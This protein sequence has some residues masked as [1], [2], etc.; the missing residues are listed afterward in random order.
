MPGV[1]ECQH[2]ACSEL[3]SRRPLHH[4]GREGHLYAWDERD[5]QLATTPGLCGSIRSRSSVSCRVSVPPAM[6]RPCQLTP[7]QIG[8]RFRPYDQVTDVNTA[9]ADDVTPDAEG[10]VVLAAQPGQGMQDPRIGCA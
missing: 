3:A 5:R 7:S 9:G 2:A 6:V 4:L 8:E 10:D 1:P